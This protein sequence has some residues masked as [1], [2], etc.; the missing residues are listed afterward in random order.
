MTYCPGRFTGCGMDC[1]Q[2]M[3]ILHGSIDLSFEAQDMLLLKRPAGHSVPTV[4]SVESTT[5]DGEG[6]EA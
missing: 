6:E 2:V 1:S 4:R 3:W 5:G